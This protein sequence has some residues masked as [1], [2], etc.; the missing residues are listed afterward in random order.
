MRLFLGSISVALAVSLAPAPAAAN[1]CMTLWLE[2]NAIFKSAGYCFGSKLGKG[3]FGNSGCHTKQPKISKSRQ[4]RVAN[5]KKREKRLGCA[6]QKKNWSVQAVRR[7]AANLSSTPRRAAPSP[8]KPRCS[9]NLELIFNISA[10]IERAHDLQV[11]G[12]S[13]T[14]VYHTLPQAFVTAR[15]NSCTGG[16][17][18]YRFVAEVDDLLDNPVKVFTGSL[19]VSNQARRCSVEINWYNGSRSLFC[20]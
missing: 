4:A 17:Y 10:R 14:S 9:Q 13:Q 3:V 16:T 1:T 8:A 20:N 6:A 2:R 7:Y 15:G 19:N 11:R 18:S 12:P 5:I